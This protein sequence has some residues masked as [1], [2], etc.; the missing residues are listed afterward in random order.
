MAGERRTVRYGI[1]GFGHFAEKAI[2][3]ALRTS[4]NS[5]VVALQ[6]RSLGAAREKARA[7]GVPRA[8]DSAE[9]LVFCPDVDAVFIVSANA[10]HCAET[11]AAA[12][13][14]KH[15]I[16]E[17]PMAMNA[18]ECEEMIQA[19]RTAGVQL[20]VAHMIRFSPLAR[21]MR[22]IVRS[23]TLGRIVSARADFVYDARLSKRS[24]LLDRKVAGGGPVF[25]I[26]V[27][28]LDMLRFVLD[29]EVVG[30]AAVLDPPPD[31]RR[32]EEV[33][34]LA[35]RFSR[36][37]IGSSFVSFRSPVRERIVEVVGEE[38]LMRAPDFTMGDVAIPL[39]L[40][41]G[42]DDRPGKRTEELI[43]VPNLY[44]EEISHFSSCIL[45]GTPQE[46]PGENGLANQRVLDRAM[47][48][49]LWSQHA[50]GPEAPPT[51]K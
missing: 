10:S 41:L 46:S 30:V 27:H 42:T 25:D 35:L 21:R 19:C 38:G 47:A 23:G 43:R 31:D 45:L 2:L 12:R 39:T 4:V 40:A 44:V 28:C 37:T 15:V 18:R 48:G 50:G 3:P 11:L 32:T 51:Q 16:V 22:E 24:W 13:A 49:G 17:K 34:S 26:G 7:C 9:E 8:F 29:D 20:M 5:E 33:A 36:G 1:V 6:K 14:G